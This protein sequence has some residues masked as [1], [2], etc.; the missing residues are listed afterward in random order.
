MVVLFV[1]LWVEVDFVC[2]CFVFVVDVIE[3]VC[4][5]GVIIGSK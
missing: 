5:E 1:K 3:G 4:I 2:V